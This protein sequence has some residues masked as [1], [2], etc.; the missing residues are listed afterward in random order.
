MRPMR[1]P[2]ARVSDPCTFWTDPGSP[3]HDILEPRFDGVRTTVV[4]VGRE[5]IQDR[6]QAHGPYTDLNYMLTRLAH[7]DTSVLSDRRAIYGDVSDFPSNPV[8]AINLVRNAESQFG[9]L[10]AEERAQYNNDWQ[11]WF[12]AMLSKPA[13]VPAENVPRE[14][15]PAEEVKSDEP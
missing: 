4:P 15:I 3:Y 2:N 6:I 12:N 5:N 9:L 8:D 10:P 7:G 14:T 11:V 1:N 13:A